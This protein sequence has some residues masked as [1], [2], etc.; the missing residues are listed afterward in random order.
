M[1]IWETWSFLITKRWIK[2]QTNP[3]GGNLDLPYSAR[4]LYVSGNPHLTKTK[5]YLWKRMYSIIIWNSKYILILFL[6]GNADRFQF[7]MEFQVH[8][9]VTLVWKCWYAQI[10]VKCRICPN[11]IYIFGSIWNSTYNP[12]SFDIIHIPWI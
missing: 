4:A 1:K 9:N 12:I 8:P 2:F 7:N 11:L 3:Y 10:I 6:S 5:Y